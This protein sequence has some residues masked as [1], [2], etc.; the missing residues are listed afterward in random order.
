MEADLYRH[1]NEHYPW[2]LM[3]ALVDRV[4]FE[5]RT[6]QPQNGVVS[7]ANDVSGSCSK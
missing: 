3:V 7:E 4:V 1:A 6:T 2:E 5:A